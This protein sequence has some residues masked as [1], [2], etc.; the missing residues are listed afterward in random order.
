MDSGR[1]R[2]VFPEFPGGRFEYDAGGYFVLSSP[3]FIYSPTDVRQTPQYFEQ[4]KKR[5]TMR[6][7]RKHQL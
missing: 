5:G 4:H 3:A 6:W 2:I 7:K 1:R